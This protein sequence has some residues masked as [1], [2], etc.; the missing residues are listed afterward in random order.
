MT[1]DEFLRLVEEEFDELEAGT[2]QA[3]KDY[4]E[5]MEWSSMNALLLMALI[6]AEFGV[7]ITA[8][9]LRNAETLQELYDKVMKLQ[10][11]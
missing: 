9:E 6:K 7:N 8:N 2:L 4:R 1:I 10:A 5:F 3:D 11:G